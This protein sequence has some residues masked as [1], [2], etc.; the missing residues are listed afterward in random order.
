MA[1]R[2]IRNPRPL[3]TPLNQAI[4]ELKAFYHRGRQSLDHNPPPLPMKLAADWFN[5]KMIDRP[6]YFMKKQLINKDN[7]DQFMPAQW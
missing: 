7:V 6:L 3:L 5:R 1:T 4:E 2:I